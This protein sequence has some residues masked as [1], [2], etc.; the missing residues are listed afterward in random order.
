MGEAQAALRRRREAALPGPPV[1]R[2]RPARRPRRAAN[3]CQRLGLQVPARV[4]PARERAQRG[5]SAPARG[6]P[7]RR[8]TPAPLQQTDSE[9]E[10][11]P[12]ALPERHSHLHG[13]TQEPAHWTN[14]RRRHPAVQE[15]PRPPRAALR[16]TG[17]AS[18]T[19]PWTPSR[20]SSPRTFSDHKTRFLP[21][22]QGRYGGAGNP[23]GPA[24]SWGLRDRLPLG[25]DLGPRQRPRPPSPVHPGDHGGR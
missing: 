20:C 15:R 7:F 6:E 8:R 9:E 4:L 13:R 24:H 11:R 10:R 18:P 12:R 16:R 19:S 5:T 25:T 3:R 23:A 17:A 22:N 2:D 21:F 14:R 1:T